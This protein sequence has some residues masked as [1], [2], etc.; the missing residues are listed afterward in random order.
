MSINLFV[1][2]IYYLHSV[3]YIRA[4]SPSLTDSA[5]EIA[6]PE[7]IKP[8]RTRKK[9]AAAPAQGLVHTDGLN[10]T[11][12]DEGPSKPKRAR[13]KRANGDGSAQGE[14]VENVDSELKPR[15]VKRK[16]K[17]QQDSLASECLPEEETVVRQP[18]SPLATEILDNLVKFPHCILLT[19]VGQFYEVRAFDTSPKY[20]Q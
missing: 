11:L 13:K 3:L 15:K 5:A 14:A 1:S 10:Q 17:K 2:K 20:F 7:L 18:T 9:R 4:A 12:Q 8:K 6:E 16:A 19:R